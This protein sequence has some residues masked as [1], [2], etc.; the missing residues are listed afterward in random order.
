MGVYVPAVAV[1]DAAPTMHR[2]LGLT[3]RDPLWTSNR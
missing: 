2:L 3:G 1:P